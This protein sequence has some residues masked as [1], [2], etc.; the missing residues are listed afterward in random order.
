[1][2]GILKIRWK[3]LCLVAAILVVIAGVAVGGNQYWLYRQPKFQDLTLELGTKEIPL[4]MFCTQYAK[5]QKAEL[6]TDLSVLQ[7]AG[8]YPVVLRHGNT[9][10]TVKLTLVDTTPPTVEFVEKRVEAVG[11]L[12]KAE[13]FVTAVTDFSETTVFF[14]DTPIIAD[15]YAV[16]E[17]TVVAE[18][19][20]GNRTQQVCT[21]VYT[22]MYEEVTLE[23]GQV[24][25]P[26]H[27]LLEP[28]KDSQLL[29]AAVLEHINTAGVGVYAVECT[30][31][32]RTLQC[33]V[34]VVD[35]TAPTLELKSV[36]IYENG[37]A[38]LEN[39][40]VQA[41]DLSGEVEL[42]LLTE[43]TFGKLGTYPVQIQ[44]T[45]INGNTVTG[46]T[47]L[48]IVT[49][50]TGPEIY[51]LSTLYVD[52]YSQ[53]DYLKGVSAYD[54]KDGSCTVDF[55]ADKVDLTKY[56]T[57]YATYTSVDRS[58][59]KSTESRKIVVNHDAADRAALVASIAQKVGSD[60]EAL[61]DYVRNE[62]AYISNWGGEDPV[63][64]GFN[65]WAGNCYV[66]AVCLKALLDY[67]GY[68]NR[69]IWVEDQSHYWLIIRLN[70]TWYH[71]DA[72]PGPVH[73]IYS[74]MD[75]QQRLETLKGRKW[76]FSQWPPCG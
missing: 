17:L 59:N 28:E 20:S 40:V 3:L 14:M 60:P 50:T 12:P 43:L 73:T 22:W 74:L 5:E 34:T 55:N 36:S 1:M 62:I 45:D 29:D 27:I 11:Y 23:L 61:R 75:D 70:G 69:M 56:G 15:D 54:G 68:E 13:D 57:Y 4:S 32:D 67:Y 41:Q 38:S 16:L 63:W 53:P 19:G 30:S 46:E 2:K 39:F 72:T 42:T 25:T 9:E 65:Q 64:Y 21:L 24:L 44:A 58:G 18:D 31:G 71:I 52:K 51:G 10:E 35:T 7:T 66:H 49:D 26:A 48:R 76:D 47:E 33:Q 6:I 8:E 37:S